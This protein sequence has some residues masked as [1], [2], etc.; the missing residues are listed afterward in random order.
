MLSFSL[1]MLLISLTVTHVS[2]VNQSEKS[3]AYMPSDIDPEYRSILCQKGVKKLCVTP[4]DLDHVFR[5]GAKAN[6]MISAKTQFENMLTECW[7]EN[8]MIFAWTQPSSKGLYSKENFDAFASACSL[9]LL[10]HGNK[11]DTINQKPKVAVDTYAAHPKQ[12][13]APE[14][15]RYTS[16][17]ILKT[18]YM[19]STQDRCSQI[20]N[21]VQETEKL[22]VEKAKRRS[23]GYAGP[24]DE[25]ITKIKAAWKSKLEK[26]VMQL[27]AETSNEA[28]FVVTPINANVPDDIRW[29]KAL[30]SRSKSVSVT[31]VFYKIPKGWS[32]GKVAPA[33][34]YAMKW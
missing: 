33:P 5:T 22:L 30:K 6:D 26:H 28:M 10:N 9:W 17:A 13:R 12:K 21:F 24:K 4:S 19:S 29:V 23:N 31:Q 8:R 3:A 7:P 2:A 14:V 11:V 15:T 34:T 32:I 1:A 18:I 27:P 20:R 25:M 16:G